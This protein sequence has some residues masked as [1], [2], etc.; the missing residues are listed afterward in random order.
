MDG[1][2][3]EFYRSAVYKARKFHRCCECCG[4]IKVGEQYTRHEGLW[5]RFQTFK[6][7]CD[8]ATL[9]EEICAELRHEED[10]PCFGY[11]LEEIF[12]SRLSTR[13]R[14]LLYVAIRERRGAPAL[15]E[16]WLRLI[17]AE[18]EESR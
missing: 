15:H 16:S 3:P 2:L 5:D 9:R 10:A 8:C 18:K 4:T 17:P 6:M 7:C 14:M 12:E 13:E 1:E 11:L